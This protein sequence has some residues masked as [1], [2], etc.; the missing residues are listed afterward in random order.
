MVDS[1]GGVTPK[2]VR[3]IQVDKSNISCSIGFH[4]HNNLQL[5]EF[6]SR[7]GGYE[8]CIE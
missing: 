7:I 2:D 5:C 6:N 4:G 1:F 3:E 8:Y